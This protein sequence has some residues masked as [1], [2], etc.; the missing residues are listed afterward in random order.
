MIYSLLLPQSVNEEY[1]SYRKKLATCSSPVTVEESEIEKIVPSVSHDPSSNV[2]EGSIVDQA[3]AVRE[4][5]QWIMDMLKQRLEQC[6]NLKK[7]LNS[8]ETKYNDNVAFIEEGEKLIAE[9]HSPGEEPPVSQDPSTFAV[10]LQKCLVSA[11]HTLML[12][13]MCVFLQDFKQRKY[14]E[15]Q[16]HTVMLEEG[17]KINELTYID[18]DNDLSDRLH[19]IIDRWFDL[20]RGFDQW[21]KDMME[22]Q[23]N[24]KQWDTQLKDFIDKL[25]ASDEANPLPTELE[26][27][28]LQSQVD[29]V[30]VILEYYQ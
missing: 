11:H 29:K 4:Q 14:N 23:E 3:T 9:N 28:K 30:Q 10:Q 21:Y 5:W 13:Y 27:S 22:A 6:S 2:Q 8:F 1:D 18:V 16:K 15:Q 26:P 20:G 19:S 12:M 7:K 17:R 24:F 25:V